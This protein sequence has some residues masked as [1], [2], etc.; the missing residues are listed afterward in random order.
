MDF[1]N[2]GL[3]G[4]GELVG[5]MDEL[6]ALDAIAGAEISVGADDLFG[7]LS[8]ISGY[9]EIVGQ[10]LASLMAAAGAEGGAPIAK[11][12]QAAKLAKVKKL[13]NAMGLAREIDPRAVAV[14]NREEDR[15]REYAL[16][17]TAPA[18]IPVGA[19]SQA[20][21]LPQVRFRP[22]RVVIPS[23]IAP[24]VTLDSI[25]V[26]KDTQQVAA[27]A[28]PAEVFT[29]VGVGVRLNMKTAI[30]GM[31]I[32]LSFTNIDALARDILFRAAII[33]TAVE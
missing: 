33:G 6:D 13:A 19:S 25:T 22:E 9:G 1:S 26:G 31:Q 17:F 2:F 30:V 11:L 23:T 28:I 8:G 29:E 15:R 24:S 21:A 18:P 14:V 3:S 16:G 32:V 20:V 27:G 10:D 4:Y 7:E 12:A 5:A